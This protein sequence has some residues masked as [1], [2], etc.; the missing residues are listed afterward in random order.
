MILVIDSFK[1]DECIDTLRL[2]QLVS[3]REHT[4]MIE[5]VINI[6]NRE[7]RLLDSC[8]ERGR[9]QLIEDYP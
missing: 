7:A 6:L 8:V 9:E 1:L 5:K 4:A 2:V 3:D